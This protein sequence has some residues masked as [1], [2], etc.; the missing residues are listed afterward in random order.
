MPLY[1]EEGKSLKIRI[2]KLKQQKL[3]L[4]LKGSKKKG[5]IKLKIPSILKPDFD[6][7]RLDIGEN[8][9]LSDQLL[10]TNGTGFRTFVIEPLKGFNLLRCVSNVFTVVD[11]MF[12]TILAGHSH[13]KFLPRNSKEADEAEAP[14]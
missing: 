9:A 13:F 11:T 8:G 1:A 12:V 3:N 6:L 7:L 2:I 14:C 4:T 10:A 5:L